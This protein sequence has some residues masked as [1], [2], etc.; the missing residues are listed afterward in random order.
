MSTN[1]ILDLSS[2][3]ARLSTQ[4]KQLVVEL[5][6]RP[7]VTIPM[8]DLAAVLIDGIDLSVSSTAT[9][10]SSTATRTAAAHSTAE[11]SSPAEFA[12]KACS[13]A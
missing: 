11:I 12:A 1:R 13:S 10:A 3:P 7:A 6:S 5:D 8:V 4:N 9:A 2:S